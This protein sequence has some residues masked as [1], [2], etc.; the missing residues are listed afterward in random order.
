MR[1]IIHSKVMEVV[2]DFKL[3]SRD[4]DHTLFNGQFVLRWLVH[5]IVNVCTKY[6]D[7]ICNHSK[8]IKGIPKFRKWSRDLSHALL[9]VKFSYSI[10]GLHAVY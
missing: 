10:K 7:S 1:S 5:F 8:D 3:R 9:G 2:P 4:P 6:E